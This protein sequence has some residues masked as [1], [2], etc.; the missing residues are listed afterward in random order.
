MPDPV[1]CLNSGSS[2][3]K[4]AVYG[5][6]SDERRLAHGA[7]EQIGLAPSR[8]WLRTGSDEV[9]ED[10]RHTI[11]D[12]ASAAREVFATLGRHGLEAA[13]AVGHRV[14]H[15]GPDFSAPRRVDGTLL[16]ALHR[17]VPLAPLHLPSEIAII[18]AIAQE[19]S[20]VAQVA[21]FDTAF[22]RRMPESAQR[23]PLPRPLWDE[24]VRRYGFH[25]LS[26]EY[27]VWKLGAAARGRLIIA[28]LGNGASLAAV[29]DGRAVDTTMGLTPLG[30]LVMGT[31]PGD[32]DPGMC[33]RPAATMP[34]D[35]ARC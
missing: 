8:V 29:L 18:E 21:C 20:D 35:S 28:H 31:R 9:V 15:G 27:V 25:G 16:A 3:L 17:L 11:D 24:G 22:H 23:L 10:T 12:H 7:V 1:L 13:A 14:V 5:V 2:S 32:L 33:Y 34:R 19:R 26:Y 6:G 30:G 4:F